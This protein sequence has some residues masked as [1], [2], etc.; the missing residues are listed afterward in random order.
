MRRI[1]STTAVLV[2]L[3]LAAGSAWAA[4]DYRAMSTEE[5]AA[6]RGA[7]QGATAE[8][9]NAFQKEWQNRLQKMSPEEHQKYMR[10]Q[11][12]AGK[13]Q[14]MGPG[15]GPMSEEKRK[16]MQKLQEQRQD[17]REDRQETRQER[18]EDRQETRQERREDRQD[19]WEERREQGGRNGGMG[20]GMGRGGMGGGR[21]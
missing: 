14:G 20:G 8:E 17:R 13:A 11:D 1:L 3:G 4:T 2:I 9:R 18:R 19:R 6:K 21:R 7:M 5:L 16:E 10:N 15:S 12:M